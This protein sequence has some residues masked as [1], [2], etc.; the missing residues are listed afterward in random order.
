MSNFNNF[1]KIIFAVLG[2]IV[3]IV[4][5]YTGWGIYK[6]TLGVLIVRVIVVILLL[7]WI[8]QLIKQIKKDK[9]QLE[10]FDDNKNSVTKALSP[11]GVKF[12]TDSLADM[13]L[14]NGWRKNSKPNL[15][16]NIFVVLDDKG[17][18]RLSFCRVEKVFSQIKLYTR[19]K[20]YFNKKKAKEENVAV[21]KIMDAGK[22]IYVTKK[23]IKLPKS[24]FD[25]TEKYNEAF[26][27]AKKWLEET[28]GLPNWNDPG[29][30]W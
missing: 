3:L 23:H 6:Q 30:Y 18:L 27:L 10:I 13:I 4:L 22:K 7:G 21:F 26:N 29:A 8:Y 24:D 11:Y 9:A 1:V 28:E 16:D 12:P 25:Y 19:Y 15:G 14:P 5:G 17:R 20:I 2:V